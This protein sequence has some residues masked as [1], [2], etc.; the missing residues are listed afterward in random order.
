MHVR[1]VILC[2]IYVRIVLRRADIYLTPRPFL[3]V[4]LKLVANKCRVQNAHMEYYVL[5][6]LR[7]AYNTRP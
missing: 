5:L 7:R 2:E 6:N 1:N 3:L 4:S